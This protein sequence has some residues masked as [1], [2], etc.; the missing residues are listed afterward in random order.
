MDPH[1]LIYP[2]PANDLVYMMAHQHHKMDLSKLASGT[3]LLKLNNSDSHS[4]QK[5]MKE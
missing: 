4:I 1:V 2:N 5:V 3:Y